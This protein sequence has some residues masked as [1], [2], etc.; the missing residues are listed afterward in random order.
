MKWDENK[1]VELEIGPIE[2]RQI[3]IREGGGWE[4]IMEVEVEEV[5]DATSTPFSASISSSCRIPSFHSN[6]HIR[7]ALPYR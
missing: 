1:V 4:E 6:W 2:G 5:A 7:S 3:A